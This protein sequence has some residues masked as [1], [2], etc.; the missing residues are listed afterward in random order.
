MTPEVFWDLEWGEFARMQ[1]G[2]NNKREHEA[3]K[4]AGLLAAIYNTI[5]RKKGSKGYTADDFLQSKNVS[6]D[7]DMSIEERQKLADEAFE[8][9]KRFEK[10]VIK[11]MCK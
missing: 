7:N 5:P 11:E 6:S 2:L 8:K 4:N 1:R 3:Y 9:A 10:G